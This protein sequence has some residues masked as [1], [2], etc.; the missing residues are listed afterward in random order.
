MS[1]AVA[2]IGA[3]I[4]GLTAALC[5]ARRGFE[6]DIIERAEALTEVG[7]GLQLSPNAS[8][9]L[10]GL[11]LL[12]KLERYW[13]EPEHIGL[14]DGVTLSPLASVSAGAFARRRAGGRPGRALVGAGSDRSGRPVNG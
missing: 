6:V 4:G 1:R 13:S 9:I 8:R 2:I 3:G 11:G 7:A 10:I 14:V 5:L 12:A